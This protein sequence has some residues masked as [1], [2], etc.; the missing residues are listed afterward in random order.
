MKY[1]MFTQLHSN[2]SSTNLA[3][4][5][6]VHSKKNEF[7]TTT[8]YSDDD[9]TKKAC[10]QSSHAVTT[11]N[12]G[13][14]KKLID[15]LV[16]D[17]ALLPDLTLGTGENAD[18]AHLDHGLTEVLEENVIELAGGDALDVIP[19]GGV[20]EERC[21]GLEEPPALGD[22]T[23]VAGVE[24][25]VAAR[26]HLGQHGL[27]VDALAA[28][29]QPVGVLAVQG[30]V[31][32]VGTAE[33]VEPASV[34]R[35]VRRAEGVR[36]G[37]DDEVLEVEAL[38]DENLGEQRDVSVGW[39]QLVGRLRCAGHAAVSPPQRDG[40][41]GSLG[42]HDGVAGHEGEDVGAGDGVG[43]GSL[44]LGLHPVHGT[45]STEALVGLG[46][47]LCQVALGGVEQDRGVTALQF[48]VVSTLL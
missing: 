7:T 9:H 46:I 13:F 17:V 36:A 27:V 34:G 43:A 3:S 12:Q 8:Q 39:R 31:R 25:L 48:L 2:L 41:G 40:P 4:K 45:K 44:E 14:S 35:A 30:W 24:G 33:V 6:T 32:A 42:K 38:G 19:G 26:V 29:P 28:C 16:D 11:K 23:V 37:E 47:P 18:V 5:T 10:A 1:I 21:I 20:G 22:V 15:T